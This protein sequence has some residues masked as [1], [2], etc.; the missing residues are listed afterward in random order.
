MVPFHRSL[1]PTPPGPLSPQV[2]DNFYSGL[3]KAF[4]FKDFNLLVF[5]ASIYIAIFSAINALWNDIVAPY[6]YSNEEA[7]IMG[8]III[9]GGL[10]G[11]GILPSN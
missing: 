2:C 1:P 9:G 3:K 10:I 11:A 4:Q 6:G 8:A 7:G 5:L